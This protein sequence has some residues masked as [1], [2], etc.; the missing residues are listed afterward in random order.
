MVFP[1]VKRFV[2]TR[3]ESTRVEVDPQ[4]FFESTGK[5]FDDATKADVLAYVESGGVDSFVVE[6]SHYVETRLDD[7]TTD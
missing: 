2:L 1:G 6:G 4:E 5:S 7:L 3:V